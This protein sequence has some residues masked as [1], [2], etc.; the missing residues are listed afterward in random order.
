MS[1]QASRSE[2][3]VLAFI[4][5]AC[6][7]AAAHAEPPTRAAE[8]CPSVQAGASLEPIATGQRRT[9]AGAIPHEARHETV[10]N[11]EEFD[12]KFETCRRC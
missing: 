6:L 12:R 4:L 2:T 8:D 7:I 3:L 11:E 10:S 1:S 9:D 5:F